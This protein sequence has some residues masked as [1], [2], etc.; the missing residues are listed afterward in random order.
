MSPEALIT[1]GIVAFTVALLIFT[2]IRPD[3]LLVAALVLIHLLGI[4]DPAQALS[5]FSNPGM[6]TVAALFV[7]AAGL[8]ETGAVQSIAGRLLGQPRSLAHAQ[9]RVMLP[10]AGLSGFLNNTPL[11]AMLMPAIT[12]WSR[13]H[14]LPA[15]KLLIPLSYASILG[16]MCTLIGTST[17]LVVNGLHV[18]A[19]HSPLGMF[20]ITAIGVPCA[21]AGLGYL[22]VF[23]RRLLPERGGMRELAADPR[24]YAVEMVVEPGGPVDGKTIGEAGLRHLPGLYLLE[25]EHEGDVL[26]AIGPHFRLSAGDHLTFVGIVGSVA[27][28][29]QIRGI[30]PATEQVFR[31]DSPRADRQLIE[32]V[33]SDSCPLVGRTI[34][35]GRFRTHYNAA[36]IAVARNGE[37]LREKVGDVVLR[38]GDT[39]L[40]EA[41]RAFADQHRDSRDFYL[42]SSM[43]EVRL[44]RHERSWISLSILAAMVIAAGTGWLTM[45]QAALLAA[46]LMIVTRC[47]RAPIAYQSVDWRLLVTIAAAL[48]TSRA[49]QDTGA[50]SGIAGWVIGAAGGRP[51]MVLAGIYALTA[52]F[53]ELLTNNAAVALMYP[54][55]AGAAADLGTGPMPFVFAIMIAG[56]SSFS[57][58]IGYQTN[59]M[60]YGTGGYRFSDFLRIGLPLSVLVGIIALLAIHLAQPLGVGYDG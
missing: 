33:V 20:A 54:I 45:L 14:S 4:L 47:C 12:D 13:R 46:G 7:V 49:M 24:E 3:L 25:V 53:T 5:G 15:S 60:V 18:Q 21:L 6:I 55:A 1:I 48:G 17:N 30:R 40:L 29:Q 42:V 43:D 52:V 58:P 2:R 10:V 44:P 31:L 56:S 32:A 16:G 26:P 35:E 37:R 39:L 23:G 11:V 19:G 28:L 38:P 8:R 9:A 50:A 36:V 57:T 27:D 51:W 41:R 34:R 59:L 22:L